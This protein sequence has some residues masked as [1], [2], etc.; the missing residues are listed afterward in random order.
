MDTEL[1]EAAFSGDVGFLKRAVDSKSTGYF[2]S[3]YTPSDNNY[4][5]GNIF[6]LAAFT[7]K[8]E[9]FREAMERLPTEVQQVLFTQSNFNGWNPLL[10][11]TWVDD[12]EIVRLILGFYKSNSGLETKPPSNSD[13]N[14]QHLSKPWLG[15]SKSK[16]TPLHV[17]IGIKPNEESAMEIL[18]MDTELL[19]AMVDDEGNSPLFL[20]VQRGLN[21]VAEKI[22][23]SS[24]YSVSGQDGSTPLHFAPKCSENVLRLLLEKNLDH[25]DAVDNKGFN[26]LHQ[27]AE[28]AEVWPFNLILEGDFPAVRT[29][30]FT[31]LMYSI[32][33]NKDGDS[34]LHIA[35]K[36]KNADIGQVLV[37]GYLQEVGASE[38]SELPD[39]PPWKTKNKNG[40]TPLHIALSSK[41]TEQ[42]ALHFLSLD[43]TL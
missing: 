27:W 4:V 29:K 40:D 16:K 38:P 39:C 21:S 1:K 15:L 42:I 18:S 43:S 34:P 30:V 2:L 9:F 8:A 26:V 35:A 19:C 13:N 20:A 3:E 22:L 14:D 37:R 33:D 36:S 6:H 24:S 11:A 32:T 17:A 41:H 10:V 7:K 25:F 23:I 31:D 5:G 28:T 12:L